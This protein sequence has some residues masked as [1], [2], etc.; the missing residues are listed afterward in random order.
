MPPPTPEDQLRFL[1][2]LQRL[3][4]EGSFTASYKYALL[5]ALANLA[6]EQGD[7]SGAGLVLDTRRIA[8]KFVAYYWR[9]VAP[10]SRTGVAGRQLLQNTD[11]QAAIVQEV[12][13]AGA[14]T[15]TLAELQGDARAYRRLVS[16]V[17]TIVEKMPLW[18]LQVIGRDNLDFLY[19]SEFEPGPHQ[20]TLFPG[21]A[22]C[23][24]KFQ[25]F[26]EELVRSAWVRFIRSLPKNRE[27]SG[28]A[29][30]LSEFLFGSE[31]ADLSACRDVLLG[32]FDRCFYCGDRLRAPVVDHFVP[33]SLY[34]VDLGHN[35]VLADA[36]CNSQKSNFLASPAHLADFCARNQAIGVELGR[37]LSEV[38][39][40][41]DLDATRRITAWAYGNAEA[42]G[43]LVWQDGKDPVKLASDWRALTWLR[44]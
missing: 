44:G 6:V 11:R 24:R 28:E 17:A 7:D 37:E 15:L 5:L 21:V 20:I 26:I 19:R 30:D 42:V 10:Y 29:S 1:Q 2:N 38:G 12:A 16:R 35:F 34:P 40:T 13:K 25:G 43:A 31:R 41:V 36:R 4:T 33:W 32:R 18:R 23:L 8:E 9:Q 14:T 27:I 3:L 39:V 22:F